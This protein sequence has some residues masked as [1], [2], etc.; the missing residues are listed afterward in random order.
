MSEEFLHSMAQSV[1]DGDREEADRLAR[2]ALDLSL[3]PL[4]AINDGYLRGL[5][6]IGD[7]FGVGDC[8]LPDL[9]MAAEAMKSAL[10][11]LEPSLQASGEKRHSFGKAVAGTVKGDIHDIGKSIVCTMLTAHGF[12][13][14]DLG[15]DVSPEQYVEAVR[16]HQPDLVMLSALLTTTMSNQQKTIELLKTAGLRDGV[17]VMVGGAPVTQEW[18]KQIEADGFGADAIEAV[19][20]AKM[21]LDRPA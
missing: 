11:I 17:R 9:V 13:V 6:V 3:P 1:I 16:Q 8:F 4:T 20:L 18:A 14:I 5:Q 12:E 7:R 15:V 10:A 19:S 2:Q 21:L